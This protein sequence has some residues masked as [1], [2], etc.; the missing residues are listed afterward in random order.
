MQAGAHVDI[1]FLFL[2]SG[3]ERKKQRHRCRG[4]RGRKKVCGDDG[5]TRDG[6]IQVAVNTSRFERGTRDALTPTTAA[7]RHLSPERKHQTPPSCAFFTTLVLPDT[8]DKQAA[9]LF[10]SFSCPKKKNQARVSPGMRRC[11]ARCPLL[12][13]A[14]CVRV[15][16]T[17]TQLSRGGWWMLPT[18]R[19]CACVLCANA[20]RVRPC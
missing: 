14:A 10:P 6:D 20:K 11:S 1:S 5:C 16:F 19:A 13:R 3:D 2:L 8:H 7:H 15:V 4:R 17:L 9:A 18:S 12:R